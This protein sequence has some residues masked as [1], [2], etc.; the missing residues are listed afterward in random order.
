MLFYG[1]CRINWQIIVNNTNKQKIQ[2]DVNK[3][4]SLCNQQKKE[5]SLSFSN[6]PLRHFCACYTQRC[7]ANQ[8]NRDQPASGESRRLP[9]LSRG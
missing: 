9:S 5:A 4:A 1:I 8:N 7:L 3:N 2:K 6:T